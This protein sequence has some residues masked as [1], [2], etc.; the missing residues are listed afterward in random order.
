MGCCLSPDSRC[1]RFLPDRPSSEPERTGWR[2]P[3]AGSR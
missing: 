3:A 1:L 2:R